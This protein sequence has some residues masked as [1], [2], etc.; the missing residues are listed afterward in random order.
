MSPKPSLCDS[1]SDQGG[2]IGGVGSAVG[3][4]AA[5]SGAAATAS[6]T[7]WESTSF[8]ARRRASDAAARA[9]ASRRVSDCRGVPT[10]SLGGRRGRT[11]RCNGN[12]RCEGDRHVNGVLMSSARFSRKYIEG[13][14]DA[15]MARLWMLR[16]HRFLCL[17][18][19]GRA[20]CALRLSLIPQY[21]ADTTSRH[22]RFCREALDRKACIRDVSSATR[23]PPAPESQV[24]AFLCQQ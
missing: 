15:T 4:L 6:A 8:D 24:A 16:E 13:R 21:H 12:A 23:R 9:R 2:D 10:G 3:A 18:K 1:V 20:P 7:A 17:R 22:A 14:P 5:S 19:E 11:A